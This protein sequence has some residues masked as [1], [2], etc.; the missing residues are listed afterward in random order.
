MRSQ[1]F[2]FGFV[3]LFP[4]LSLFLFGRVWCT[5]PPPMAFFLNA[6][7]VCFVCFIEEGSDVVLFLY[8]VT[9]LLSTPFLPLF[10]VCLSFV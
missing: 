8:H 4:H 6:I 3:A 2:F 5:Y 7:C 9:A 10:L 1:L